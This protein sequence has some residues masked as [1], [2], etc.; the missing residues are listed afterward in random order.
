MK[1]QNW[2][3]EKV[4]GPYKGPNS[5]LAWDGSGM[6]FSLVEEGRIMRFDPKAKKTTQF[7]NYTNR[8]TGLAFGGVVGDGL[9][10]HALALDV[11]GLERGLGN[12]EQLVDEVAH[13]LDLLAQV[14]DRLLALL[15]GA[16]RREHVLEFQQ[17]RCGALPTASRRSSRRPVRAP[18]P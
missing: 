8:I 7:R 13:V 3:F 4:A 17:R 9:H 10:V 6:L 11:A 12:G 15:D 5:G 16:T 18:V 2:K 1:T 14:L